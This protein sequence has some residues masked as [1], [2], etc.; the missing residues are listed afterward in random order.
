MVFVGKLNVILIKLQGSCLQQLWLV[1]LVWIWH[2]NPGIVIILSSTCR[3][4]SPSSEVAFYQYP[5]YLVVC[6][7]QQ[8]PVGFLIISAN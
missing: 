1:V 5:L 2:R 6:R 8:F 4:A 7:I 3:R